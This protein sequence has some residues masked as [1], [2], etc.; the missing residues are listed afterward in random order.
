MVIDYQAKRPGSEDWQTQSVFFLSKRVW[1][2]K[3]VIL[4]L[5]H[6]SNINQ[7]NTT[8]FLKFKHTLSLLNSL[9]GSKRYPWTFILRQHSTSNQK[10]ITDWTTNEKSYFSNMLFYSDRQK[11]F[12]TLNHY[13]IKTFVN[14][15]SMCIKIFYRFYWRL[16][17]T[18]DFS[19]RLERP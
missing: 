7:R 18:Y 4:K 14:C 12:T 9:E 16:C 8:W 19:L 11:P 3:F 17:G 6:S 5:C 10:I 13:L 2:L 15:Q 1:Y